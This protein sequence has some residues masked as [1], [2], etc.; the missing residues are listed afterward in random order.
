MR[1]TFL[2]CVL[3]LLSVFCAGSVVSAQDGSTRAVRVH[4]EVQASPKQITL[5]WESSP[6]EVSHI[7]VHRRAPGASTWVYMGNDPAPSATQWVDTDVNVGERYEYRVAR[8]HTNNSYSA[9]GYIVAGIDAELK[10]QRGTVILVVDSSKAGALAPEIARFKDDLVGDGWTVVEEQVAPS[11]TPPSVRAKLQAIYNADPANV[12]AAI[13]LGRIPVP[14]SGEISPDGHNPDH[15]GAWPADT[16]YA[17]LTGTWTDTTVN[18]TGASQERNRNVPGDGKFDQS[19]LPSDANI[20][21]GR[22]DMANLSGFTAGA[23][24][25]ELLR[26]YL[27]KNHEFRHQLGAFA[28]VP[29]RGLI[30]DNFEFLS[31]EAPASVGWRGFTAMFGPDHVTLASNWF[32]TLETNKYLWAYGN[33]PGGYAGASGIGTSADFKTKDSLAVFNMLF[34]SYFGDWDSPTD[35]FLRAPLAGTPGS[36]TLVTTWGNR[37]DWQVH[38]MTLGETI[39]DAYLRTLNNPNDWGDNWWLGYFNWI[40]DT[41]R[42]VH[43]ALMGDPTLR[44]HPIAPPESG[45]IGRTPGGSVDSVALTW[46]A[47]TVD[48]LV[49]YHVYRAMDRNGPF[50]RLT[51]NPVA[52]L[53]YTDTSAPQEQ[54]YYMVRAVALTESASGTYYNAGQALHYSMPVAAPESAPT[55]LEAIALS[56]ST[57]ELNWTYGGEVEV[58]LI[59]RRVAGTSEWTE[60]ATLAGALRVYQDSDLTAGVEY[61]YRIF[62]LNSLGASP[63]SDIISATTFEGEILVFDSFTDGGTN[64]GADPLDV[65]WSRTG[66]TFTVVQDS[67]LDPVAP[68]NVA[69]LHITQSNKDEYLYFPMPSEV[70]LAVGETLRVDFRLRHTGPPRPDNSRTGVSLA[71]T[72]S[73]SPWGNE[74]NRE[75]FFLTSFGNAGTLGSIRRTIGSQL[76]NVGMT[77][78]DNTASINAG[79]SVSNVRLEVTRLGEEQVRIRYRLNDGPQQE[80]IDTGTDVITAFNRVFFRFRTRD[81]AENP[82]EPRFRLDDVTVTRIAAAPALPGPGEI[83]FTAAVFEAMEPVYDG[84]PATATKTVT[85]TVERTG[86]SEGEVSVPYT[87]TALESL[88]FAQENQGSV[89]REFRTSTGR[90][91]V[92]QGSGFLTW[93]DGE[94][95]EKSFTFEIH[96]DKIWENFEATANPLVEGIESLFMFLGAP[97]GGATLGEH[98]R[99]RFDILDAEAPAGGQGVIQFERPRYSAFEDAGTMPIVLRRVQ[100]STGTVSATFNASSNLQ[101]GYDGFTNPI[102]PATAGVHYTAFTQTVT[103][104]DG[105]SEDK[106]VHVP[107]FD[108]SDVHSATNSRGVRGIRLHLTNPTGGAEVSVNEAM[109][110]ILDTNSETF[111]VWIEN[112]YGKRISIRVPRNTETI[113]GLIYF[114]PGTGGDWRYKVDLPSN[115]AVADQWGFAIAGQLANAFA[116]NRPSGIAQ[117]HNHLDALALFTGRPELRNVPIIFTGISAGGYACTD[118]HGGIPG[119]VLGFVAHKGGAYSFNRGTSQY[120]TRPFIH[121]SNLFTPGMFISGGNDG[122]VTAKDIYDDFLLYRN[123]LPPGSQFTTAMDWNIGHTANDGQG[124]AMT[125]L[126]MDELIRTRYPA[127]QLPGTGFGEIVDLIN[128]PHEDTWLVGQ[129]DDFLANGRPDPALASANLEIR[130]AAGVEDP[131]NDGIVLTERLARAIQAFSSLHSASYQSAVPFQSPLRI[132]SHTTTHE[133]ITAIDLG[134]STTVTLDPRGYSNFN[135]ADFYFNN[136]LVG[137]L[138]SAPW[139]VTFTPDESGV[140]LLRVETSTDGGG[141]TRYAFETLLVRDIPPVPPA[142]PTGLSVSRPSNTTASLSWD[143]SPFT[144]TI[145]VQ[146]SATGAEGNWETIATLDGLATSYADSGLAAGASYWY[147]LIASN[148]YGDSP[149]TAAAVI[150]VDSIELLVHDP[151]TDGGTTQGA[152]PLD[153][154]WSF[155]NTNPSNTTFTVVEDSLLDPVAPH[156]VA[157]LHIDANNTER[158][159]FF[160]LPSAVN[161]AVDE[162]LRVSFRLRHTGTPRADASATGVSLA[163]TPGNAPWNNAN[164]REYFLR[165]SFGSDGNLADIRKTGSGGA[166]VLN[167][168]TETLAANLPAIDAGTDPVTVQLEVYRLGPDSVRVRYQL[169]ENAPQEVVDTGDAVTAFN[170]VFIRLRTRND[171]E[172]SGEPQFHLDDVRVEK[173]TP[174]TLAVPGT[175][176]DLTVGTLSQTSLQISWTPA[177]LASGYVL[178]RSLTGLEGS[179]ST[180]DDNLSASETSFTDTGLSIE[181]TY[182]YRIRAFNDLGSSNW[183][184]ASGTTQGAL[185]YELVLPGE[186]AEDAES[187]Q[188]NVTRTTSVGDQA[189]LLSTTSERLTVPAIVT[190][191][192]GQ[193]S[194]SFQ[195]GVLNDEGLEGSELATIS[196]FAPAASAGESFA[197]EGGSALPGNNGGWGFAAAWSGNDFAPTLGTGVT[198]SKNGTIGDTATASSRFANGPNE[199]GSGA[200]SAFRNLAAPV[201]T[202]QVWLSYLHHRQSTNWSTGLNVRSAA[203]ASWLHIDYRGSEDNN[204]ALVQNQ[205]VRTPLLASDPRPAVHLFVIQLDFEAELIRVWMNPDASGSAPANEESFAEI[206][207]TDPANRSLGRI[208][209]NSWSNPNQTVFDEIDEIRVA[210]SFADLYGGVSFIGQVEILETADVLPVETLASESFDNNTGGNLSIADAAPDWRVHF[211]ATGELVTNPGF[212]GNQP[213]AGVSNTASHPDSPD[214]GTNGVAYM[215]YGANQSIRAFL[216]WRELEGGGIQTVENLTFDWWNLHQN[217]NAQ[218]R[219]AV[220]IDG[221]WYLHRTAF[222]STEIGATAEFSSKASPASVAFTFDAADWSAFSFVPG[223][224]FA[225]TNNPDALGAPLPAG[226]ITAVGVYNYTVSG[227]ETNGVSIDAFTITGP[228]DALLEAPDILASVAVSFESDAEMADAF[229]ANHGSASRLA[230]AGL[231]GSGALAT[232]GNPQLLYRAETFTAAEANAL[233]VYVHIGE[234]ANSGYDSV[235]AMLGFATKPTMNF[236]GGASDPNVFVAGRV[237]NLSNNGGY[238]LELINKTAPGSAQSVVAGGSTFALSNRDWYYVRKVM[239]PEGGN[240]FAV[241]L[242]VYASDASGEIGEMVTSLTGEVINAEVAADTRLWAVLR[243]RRDGNAAAMDDFS[244][245]SATLAPAPMRT[246][247]MSGQS[248]AVGYR[249]NNRNALPEVI[250]NGV[251]GVRGAWLVGNK[252]NN[253]LEPFTSNGWGTLNVQNAGTSNGPFWPNQEGFGP[254]ITLARYLQLHYETDIA[255]IKF[256]VNGASLFENFDP[257]NTGTSGYYNTMRDYLRTRRTELEIQEDREASIEAFFWLQGESDASSSSP[258]PSSADNYQANLVNFVAAVRTDLDAPEMWFVASQINPRSGGFTEENVAKVNNALAA[259]SVADPLFRL[260]PAIDLHPASG[261]DLHFDSPQ[262]ME[263]GERLAYAYLVGHADSTGSGVDDAWELEAF[264]DLEGTP[265]EI[266]GQFYSRRT[267]YIWN[268]PNPTEDLFKMAGLQFSTVEGRNYQIEHRESLTEGEWLPYGDIIEGGSAVEVNNP[269]PGFYRVRVMLP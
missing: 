24:E 171:A 185:A 216:L 43:V 245:S 183:E 160:P 137:T 218:S 42:G 134:Q 186:V 63:A 264:G 233:G 262:T 222:T 39:G 153:V 59:E 175:V 120:D 58:F 192:D 76:L 217:A 253:A 117:F 188:A 205:G 141:E 210:S 206:A 106:V 17:D 247:V 155:T 72:P 142:T 231:S 204:W 169:G 144:A 19:N 96:S 167:V 73:N 147:R 258:Q 3:A 193:N 125:Y 242:E 84:T 41:Q 223:T 102:T 130:P 85:V 25:T 203:G 98:P 105:D 215:Y 110:L 189:V 241:M 237:L 69:E 29:R 47:V 252:N 208:L 229:R 213:T 115:Q 68:H 176:S 103:W 100:G 179:W 99:A 93:A 220:R 261:D 159:L 2:P 80:A 263:I 243:S 33:G 12:K 75:Y 250:R 162:G 111:D 77:L 92:H 95:G 124:W 46:D 221:Q 51:S 202:G 28:D 195:V 127:G 62:A 180:L 57:I 182:Y 56:D 173:L 146:R 52:D 200:S 224:A 126:F 235:T 8:F 254:E 66:G 260:S 234:Q 164:N 143:S 196:A 53:T 219:L 132:S 10:D 86:G 161:L 257:G 246:F 197:Y 15:R 187:L 5:K 11:D 177:A 108:N 201:S 269:D 138:T 239:T 18:N 97:R 140:A 112:Q 266:D 121:E 49:G 60:V 1:R 22:I 178:E 90:P 148:T 230:S 157:R 259:A 158:Y 54:L 119:Q 48:G 83:S 145:L 45:T 67:T 128:V 244:V 37:P 226:A 122:T 70:T 31:S 207:M 30:R 135:Q 9:R 131:G 214:A 129:V 240:T 7:Y 163:F 190:I 71:H 238:R 225:V 156:H 181:T 35:N 20:A 194:V 251:S 227:A 40:N 118:S 16:Y 116:T 14:Y 174:V 87:V 64:Q 50:A 88:S 113:R 154:H 38:G 107:L 255:V 256:A 104:E 166:Q 61:E 109:G 81:D 26:N 232:T 267:L 209:L 89:D 79:T 74:N 199:D 114:L 4:A 149:A 236:Q 123:N 6:H 228:E 82:G 265:V 94:S 34:G 211:S 248:N 172:N 133:Q 27:R 268:L 32:P 168:G 65:N 151:F 91:F 249:S 212:A 55:D 23:N 136:E 152:D 184:S 165:T 21:I 36:L 101:P 150:L 191:P 78:Q 13:L 139:S 44:L 170:R 198:Y